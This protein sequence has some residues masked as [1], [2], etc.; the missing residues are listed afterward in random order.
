MRWPM[1]LMVTLS[2]GALLQGRPESATVCEPCPDCPRESV[3]LELLQDVAECQAEVRTLTE[4]R[5][6]VQDRVRTVRV[7]A[8]TR[9]CAPVPEIV[10]VQWTECLPGHTC[11]DDRAHGALARNLAAYQAFVAVC[12]K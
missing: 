2:C 3:I 11:L 12:A 8:P 7:P 4:T 1:V 6:E 5:V 10:P 9:P